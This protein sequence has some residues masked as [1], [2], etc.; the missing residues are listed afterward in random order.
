MSQGGIVKTRRLAIGGALVL[1]L[2][3]A[4]VAASIGSARSSATF[5]VAV[6]SDI[7]SIQDKGFN[8]LANKG[9]LVV[10]TK[11]DDS[12]MKQPWSLR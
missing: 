5:R 1:A 3:A 2:A 9:R 12:S 8:E 4:L 6:V 7:G 11:W 10:E